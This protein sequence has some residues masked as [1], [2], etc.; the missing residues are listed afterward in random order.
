MHASVHEDARAGRA[1]FQISVRNDSCSVEN[2]IRD[3]RAK[4]GIGRAWVVVESLYSMDGDF[5]L[6][7]DL[8]AMADRYDAFLIV[9]E[10]H[11]TGVYGEQGRELTAPYEGRENRLVVH[12]CGKALGAA[13]ALVTASGVLRDFTVNR[14]RPFIFVTAPSSLM[15]IAARAALSILQEKSERQQH[16]AKLVAFTHLQMRIRGLAKSFGLADRALYRWRQCARNAACLCTAG[17]WLLPATRV[18]R[19]V[20]PSPGKIPMLIWTDPQVVHNKNFQVVRGATGAPITLV[21]HP[22]RYDGKLPEVRLPPQKLGAQ[23]G[24]SS[25]S[26]ATTTTNLKTFPGRGRSAPLRP[27]APLDDAPNAHHGRHAR[28]HVHTGHA[29]DDRAEADGP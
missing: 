23:T 14:C 22:V 4:G 11:A 28:A 15:A 8:V 18:R 26:S 25:K 2:T 5:A 13:G 27:R 29:R 16:L 17:S 19:W 3:W 9:D 12:T 20:A 7:E 24:K 1:E 10:A 21:S 6:L